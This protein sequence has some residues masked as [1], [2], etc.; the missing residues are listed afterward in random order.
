MEISSFHPKY[1]KPEEFEKATP[2]C[3]ITDMDNQ[4]LMR[5]DA[6]RAQCGFP[7]VINSAYRS[8][9]YELSK[10]R[11]GLSFHTHGRAVDIRCTDAKKRAK[12]IL[13]APA[14]G[15]R[16]IGVSNRYVHLDDRE[17]NMIWSYD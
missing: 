6:L 15:L 5:L 16:G 8:V 1:F 10:H 9:S 11:D 17:D 3:L 2:S 14:F 4:F 12:I 13:Y 7:F